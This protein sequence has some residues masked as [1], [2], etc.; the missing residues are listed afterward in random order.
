M[1]H[2][3]YLYLIT[4]LRNVITLKPDTRFSAILHFY[5]HLYIASY[6]RVWV[7]LCFLVKHVMVDLGQEVNFFP[8]FHNVAWCSKCTLN[9][10]VWWQAV[11]SEQL[12]II[13]NYEIIKMYPFAGLLQKNIAVWSY[14][15]TPV[16]CVL[17]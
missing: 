12:Q 1:I 4:L 16:V 11:L 9:M 7:F 8:L 10:V 5:L 13:A 3:P 14:K 6:E 15:I 17:W 2:I